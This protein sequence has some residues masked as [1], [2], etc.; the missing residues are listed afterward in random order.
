MIIP[1]PA[2]LQLPEV[3]EG[4][5]ISLPVTFTVTPEGMIPVEI[6]GYPV[7]DNESEEEMTDAESGSPDEDFISAVNRQLK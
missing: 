7:A 6:D 5:T 1:I 3:P 2:G 4:E